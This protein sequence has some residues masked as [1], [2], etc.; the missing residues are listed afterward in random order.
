MINKNYMKTIDFNLIAIVL[1]LFT[2]GM[3]MITSATDAHIVGVTREVRNQTLGF[4]IGISAMLVAMSFDYKTFKVFNRAVYILSI[5][6]ML[7][8]YIPGLG[9]VQF[10]ARSWIDL[11]VLYFQPAEIAK[12]GFILT[13]ANLLEEKKMDM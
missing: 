10:G 2:F 12:L 3:I 13:Y 5:L 8:V 1:I 6:I 4:V 9:V 11:K 7:T